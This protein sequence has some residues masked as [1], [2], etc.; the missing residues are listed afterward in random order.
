MIEYEEMAE[1]YLKAIQEPK[2]RKLFKV[3]S[4]IQ[5]GA[6]VLDLEEFERVLL[7]LIANNNLE[8]KERVWGAK[9]RTKLNPEQ[10]T[11]FKIIEILNKKILEI[12]NQ[13]KKFLAEK[14]LEELTKAK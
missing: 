3:I 14:N 1:P 7:I 10:E 9:Y 6:G 12:E 11:D 4:K 5:R 8:Y 2:A 13:E